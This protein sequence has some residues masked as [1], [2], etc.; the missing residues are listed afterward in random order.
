MDVVCRP[1]RRFVTWQ[2]RE[3]GRCG[4]YSPGLP[5]FWLHWHIAHGRP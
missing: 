3:C 1:R 5:E 2:C 4:I